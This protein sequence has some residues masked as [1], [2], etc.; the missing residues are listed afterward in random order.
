MS[1]YKSILVAIDLHPAYD[2]YTAQRAVE[3]AKEHNAKLYMIHCVENIH[4]Y[5][6]A[7]GYQ[8]IMEV[9]QQLEQEARKSLDQLATN[10]GIPSEQQFLE[11]GGA[12]QTV[13]LEKAKELQVDLIIVGGHGRH[14][15]SLLLGSIA[16]GIIHHAHCDVLAI[17][18]K[19]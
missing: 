7:Q 6:A 16:D 19:K 13:V 1:I 10:L 5:G 4:A 3:F 12:V 14:G 9:E 15:I 8:L 18:A 2:E 11:M 17:R